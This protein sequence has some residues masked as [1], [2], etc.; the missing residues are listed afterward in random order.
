MKPVPVS[1]P[2]T[3]RSLDERLASL[4]AALDPLPGPARLT[5]DSHAARFLASIDDLLDRV[6][7]LTNWLA[8]DSA[9]W[10]EASHLA[11]QML[12]RDLSAIARDLRGV[13]T[14]VGSDLGAAEARLRVVSKGV[15]QLSRLVEDGAAAS[16]TPDAP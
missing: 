6:R 4:C 11:A 12:L 8:Q 14:V 15:M 13:T 1:R 2:E 16:A 10:D 7:A 9:A 3:P 5:F